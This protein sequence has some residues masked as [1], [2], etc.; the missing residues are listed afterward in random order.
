MPAKQKKTGSGILDLI[1]NPISWAKELIEPIPTKLNNRSTATLSKYGDYFI[2][3]VI[4]IIRTP[5]NSFLTG[6]MNTLSFGKFAQIQKEEGVN[7]LYH[8]SI[9][10][11]IPDGPKIIIEKNEVVNIAVFKPSDTNTNTEYFKLDN[12]QQITL[13]ELINNTLK[14]MGQQKFYDYN[15]LQTNTE[16]RN[17]CQDFIE[18]ILDSNRLMTPQAHNFLYQDLQVLND[19]LNDR[20]G[21]YVTNGMKIITSLGSRISRLIA[22]GK[23]KEKG[24][25]SIHP[26]FIRLVKRNGLRFL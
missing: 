23:E 14:R 3:P 7:K 4:D 9:I 26:K 1:K 2:G 21:G 16:K 25:L 15:G 11:S 22:K 8:L 5:L 12:G 6:A 20:T 19:K 10:V 13:S 18:N 24:K 17:N